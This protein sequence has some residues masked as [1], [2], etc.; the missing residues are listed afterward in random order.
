MY[1]ANL[2]VLNLR[3]WKS[4]CFFLWTSSFV[5][6]PLCPAKLIWLSRAG[7]D[8]AIKPDS[9]EFMFKFRLATVVLVA[10][11][12][13]IAPVA[14]F[15]HMSAPH[16]ADPDEIPTVSLAV[17]KDE[18]GGFNVQITTENFT[19]APEN[20]SQA[21]VPGEGHAHIYVDGIK[22]GRVYSSWFHLDTATL[23]IT[24]GVHSVEVDLNGND[25]GSYIVDG[26]KIQAAA[27]ILVDATPMSAM[28]HG[29][30]MAEGNMA[31]TDEVGLL[32]VLGISLLGAFLAGGGYLLGRRS[33][34]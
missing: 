7:R 15:A 2:M 16:E 17:N 13:L 25:H 3:L 19:W 8:T 33:R 24:P 6:T 11:F 21:H 9:R 10:S 14:S 18:M 32:L 22:V 27:E 26:E 20:A 1:P 23:G 5:C 30:E 34:S 4:D 28:P 29:E 31:Q 12:S